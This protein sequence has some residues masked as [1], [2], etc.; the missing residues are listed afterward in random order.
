M[1]HRAPSGRPDPGRSAPATVP[2]AW[3]PA[4]MARPRR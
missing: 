4:P 2:D 3:R 1:T